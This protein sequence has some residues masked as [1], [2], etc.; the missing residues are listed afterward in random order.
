MYIKSILKSREYLVFPLA[1]RRLTLLLSLA[2][3][4]NEEGV[5]LR[6]LTANARGLVGVFTR[7]PSSVGTETVRRYVPPNRAQRH[8]TDKSFGEFNKFSIVPDVCLLFNFFR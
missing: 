5:R 6:R 4:R 7:R 2:A 8:A 3:P 1:G